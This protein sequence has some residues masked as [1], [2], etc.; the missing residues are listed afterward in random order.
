MGLSLE[1]VFLR[2]SHDGVEIGPG[3]T[4]GGKLGSFPVHQRIE[5]R[6]WSLRGLIG[7][8][9]GDIH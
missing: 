1:K 6:Q 7:R 9:L 2:K 5:P 3:K 8:V 4:G